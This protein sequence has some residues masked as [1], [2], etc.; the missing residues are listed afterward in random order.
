MSLASSS[1]SNTRIQMLGLLQRLR[2]NSNKQA[3]NDRLTNNEYERYAT[4]DLSPIFPP[5]VQ[6]TLVAFEFA[7]SLSGRVLSN[8]RSKL[9]LTSLEMCMCLKDHL[10]ATEGIQHTSNIEDV[11]YDEEVKAGKAILLYDEEI[12]QDKAASEARY[13]GS[14]DEIT[15]D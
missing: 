4:T 8:K 11:V 3:K 6:A 12:A 9:T 7:F 5:F 10:D 13:N 14:E 2:E 15:F 1:R